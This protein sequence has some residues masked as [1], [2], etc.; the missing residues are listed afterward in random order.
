[1]NEALIRAAA[2]ADFA[3]ILALNADA[4]VQT[5]A[6]D[7]ARLGELD[8]QAWYHR[9]VE[10]DGVVSGFLLVLDQRSQIE[11]ANFEWFLARYSHFAYVDRIVIDRRSTSNGLGSA[12]YADLIRQA[13]SSEVPQLCCEYNLQPPNPGS[14]AFH[15][16]HGFVEVGQ[17]QL[18]S[19]KR[20]SMQRLL[21]A[22][23]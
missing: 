2:P 17:Q 18:S 9:V 14:A 10:M 15:A 1:M 23:A 3:R 22:D 5:S 8:Q 21:L 13:R 4:E 19:S 16:R 7:L 12:L 6:L 20:V 11:G